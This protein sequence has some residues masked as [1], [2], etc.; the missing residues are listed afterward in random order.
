VKQPVTPEFLARTE[1]EWSKLAVS[2]VTLS[3]ASGPIMISTEC[4]PA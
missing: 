1:K 4:G 2:G 3:S